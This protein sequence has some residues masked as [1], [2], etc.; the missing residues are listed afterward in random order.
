MTLVV[1][2]RHP[3]PLVGDP[4]GDVHVL[5]HVREADRGRLGRVPRGVREEVVE[6][7]HDAPP[8]GHQGGSPRRQVDENG[9]PAAAA[10]EAASRPLH[11]GGHVRGLR[12]DRERARVRDL[13]GARCRDVGVRAVQAIAVALVSRL[14][15]AGPRPP[16]PGRLLPHPAVV[17]GAAI[18]APESAVRAA[19]ILATATR[20]LDLE[21]LRRAAAALPEQVDNVGRE[22][23]DR[24]LIIARTTPPLDARSRQPAPRPVRLHGLQVDE[25]VQFRV[26]LRRLRRRLDAA[27]KRV[28][29]GRRRQQ[30][31]FV[32]AGAAEVLD[33]ALAGEGRVGGTDAD[34][35]VAGDRQ[36]VPARPVDQCRVRIRRH[37][38]ADLDEVDAGSMQI[39]DRGPSLGKA[40]DASHDRQIERQRTL[41]DRP[42]RDEPRTAR[43]GYR[44]DSCKN[45]H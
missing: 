12:R 35:Q 10:Q 24:R 4:D 16:W 13:V 36:A 29:L 43:L 33:A 37:C 28:L 44:P 32:K 7:L 27:G 3:A 8:V 21:V 34:G 26:E 40:V 25:T 31:Q 15:G 9:V 20:G 30:Q 6:H 38:V 18:A 41:Q 42:G 14:A 19:S 5:A 11:Q 17:A 1:P 39:V 22:R 23:G 45:T 2:A